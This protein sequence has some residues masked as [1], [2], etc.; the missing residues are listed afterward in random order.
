[1]SQV[2]LA[3]LGEIETA[4]WQELTR[5]VHDKHHEWRTL[6]LSTVGKV[7]DELTADARNVVLREVNVSAKQLVIY[8]DARAS[9]TQQLREHPL[10]TV[11]MWSRRLGWQLRCRVRLNV[12]D[13]GLAVTS[14]WEALKLSPAAQ[15]YFSP[16]APGVP[17]T[18]ASAA[19]VSARHHF[20]VITAEVLSIDW[21]ELHRE[22]HRRAVIGEQPAAWVQA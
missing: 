18:G 19:A 20:A 14:R 4:L 9:K 2:R 3:T 7:G 22:G 21:L 16:L 11:V 1:M 17:L 13:S 8:T 5:A 12:E 15:D 10:G 6:V